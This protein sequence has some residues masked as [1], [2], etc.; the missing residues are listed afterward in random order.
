MLSG[1]EY[2]SLPDYIRFTHWDDDISDDLSLLGPLCNLKEF[3][4]N[5]GKLL[6]RCW[7]EPWAMEDYPERLH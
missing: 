4:L 5:E 2:G 3:H 7:I 6:D 1:F